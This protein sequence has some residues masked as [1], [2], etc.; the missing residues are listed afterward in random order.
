MKK[1]Y[2]IYSVIIRKLIFLLDGVNNKI[3]TDFYYNYL[4]VSSFE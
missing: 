2:K 3:F 4:N 1:I